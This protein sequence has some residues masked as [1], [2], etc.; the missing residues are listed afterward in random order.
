MRTAGWSRKL[1]LWILTS[2]RDRLNQA[3]PHCRCSKAVTRYSQRLAICLHTSARWPQRFC[4]GAGSIS[5]TQNRQAKARLDP[6]VQRG[7][8]LQHEKPSRHAF[9]LSF[10]AERS[11]SRVSC[12]RWQQLE[13]VLPGRL[14]LRDCC[15]RP[16]FTP[17]I[18]SLVKWRCYASMSGGS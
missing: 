14:L 5:L 2:I 13:K 8:L 4:F 9:A 10:L 3:W 17:T 6:A 7:Q 1:A 16:A 18:R 15:S 11:E 12:N